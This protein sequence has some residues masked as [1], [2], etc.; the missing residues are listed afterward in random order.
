M[1]MVKNVVYIN[2]KKEIE[3]K[4]KLKKIKQATHSLKES[5]IHSLCQVSVQ[6]DRNFN[7]KKFKGVIGPP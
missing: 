4:R 2:K 6:G 5:E 3:K 1:I 7:F